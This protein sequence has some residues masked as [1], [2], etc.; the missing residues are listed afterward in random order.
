M[1]F[2][3]LN[4]SL[5]VPAAPGLLWHNKRMLLCYMAHLYNTITI[6][7]TYIIRGTYNTYITKGNILYPKYTSIYVDSNKINEKRCLFLFTNNTTRCFISII[8]MHSG[9]RPETVS[10]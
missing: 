2:S 6:R 9:G 8:L 3:S 10:P 1:G 4:K 5:T 7:M